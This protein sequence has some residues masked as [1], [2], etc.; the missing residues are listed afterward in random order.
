MTTLKTSVYNQNGKEVSSIELPESVFGVAW[1]ADFIHQV[2]TSLTSSAREG[3]AHAKTR[4][5]VRGG[6]RK[7]WKQK[8]L[9]KARHGS[10]RSPIW[11]GGGTTHGPRNDKNYDRK[12]N[13]KA[14]VKALYTVLSKK[15]R[16][17]EML[18]VD[19]LAFTEPKTKIAR[20]TLTHLSEVKGF[21]AL[22]NKR[23]NAAYIALDT[24]NVAVEKSFANFSNITVAEMRNINLVDILN[25]KFVVIVNPE[26]AVKALEGKVTAQNK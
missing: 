22:K 26:N 10:S 8:G 19:S 2:V 21:M 5:E 23:N 18:F 7:P 24:K 1:N 20:E 4:G 11:V 6:G 14:K 15:F 12:V 9:G 17:G 3:A 13:K 25:Y 16:D